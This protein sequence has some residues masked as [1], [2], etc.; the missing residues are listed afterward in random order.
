MASKSWATIMR[1]GPAVDVKEKDRV[2][3]L[4]VLS[5]DLVRGYHSAHQSLLELDERREV[6]LSHLHSWASQ[7]SQ[8]CLKAY[9]GRLPS[10]RPVCRCIAD[11]SSITCS[12]HFTGCKSVFTEVSAGS[13]TC[14]GRQQRDGGGLGLAYR[15]TISF[16][17]CDIQSHTRLSRPWVRNPIPFCGRI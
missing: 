7:E 13:I 16:L 1:Y 5:S 12:C 14:R 17:D 2:F 15:D 9:S 10:I 3:L 4:E 11:H 6:I 8:P